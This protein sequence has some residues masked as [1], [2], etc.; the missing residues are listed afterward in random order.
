MGFYAGTA[1]YTFMHFSFLNSDRG[2][3]WQGLCGWQTSVC[4]GVIGII[5]WAVQFLKVK[6]DIV[7]VCYSGLVE[8]SFILHVTPSVKHYACDLHRYNSSIF[9][10]PSV[11][12][13]IP[14]GFV[15][16]LRQQHI[17]TKLHGDESSD[18]MR[19][20]NLFCIFCFGFCY[21]TRSS[22]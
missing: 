4:C 6:R 18:S 3:F 10:N 12:W 15:E 17:F 11:F 22:I 7:A 8:I 5:Y 19:S 20:R 2:L 16:L 13:A 1:A 21:L 14:N 9:L